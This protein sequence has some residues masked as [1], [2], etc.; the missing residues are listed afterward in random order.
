MSVFKNATKRDVAKK[1]IE[2]PKD[3]QEFVNGG[4]KHRCLNPY[5]R[6]GSPNKKID[7][8]ASNK[9]NVMLNI[10]VS[11][12]QKDFIAKKAESKHMPVSLYV[13]TKV[14]EEDS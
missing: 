7:G 14:L 3:L 11:Q 10:Y 12:E 8:E 13:L 6:R 9:R 2:V 1:D 5:G 4:S